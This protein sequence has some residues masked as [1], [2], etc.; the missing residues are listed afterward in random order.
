MMRVQ[1][2]ARRTGSHGTTWAH[3]HGRRM[4]AIGCGV[5]QGQGLLVG[6]LLLLAGSRME[7]GMWMRRLLL[8]LVLIGYCCC[9]GGGCS[10][11]GM[12]PE[13]LLKAERVEAKGQR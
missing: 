3:S 9:S 7:P 10:C 12:E 5:D 8:L 1:P 2:R 6:L 4:V 11:A 13:L